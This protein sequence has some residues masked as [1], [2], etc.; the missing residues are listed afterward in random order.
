MILAFLDEILGLTKFLIFYENS[1]ANY[2]LWTIFSLVGVK[3]ITFLEI[4]AFECIKC[5]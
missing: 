1:I 5:K 2:I 4:L 3:T